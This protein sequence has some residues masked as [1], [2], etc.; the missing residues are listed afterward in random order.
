MA[1]ELLLN[2]SIII[3]KNNGFFVCI[4]FGFS[5]LFFFWFL[6]FD[7]LFFLL[8]VMRNILNYMKVQECMYIQK[9]NGYK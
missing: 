3:R 4:V 7:F 2:Q 9:S 1:Y 5:F 6:A 8:L